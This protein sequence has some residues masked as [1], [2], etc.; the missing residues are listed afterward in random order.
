MLRAEVT[1][2][3]TNGKDDIVVEELEVTIVPPW[4]GR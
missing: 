3:D 4:R 1:A 2:L